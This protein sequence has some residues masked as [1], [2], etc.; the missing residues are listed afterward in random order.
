MELLSPV[1]TP[2]GLGVGMYGKLQ[3]ERKLSAVC[4]WNWQLWSHCLQPPQNTVLPLG[5][6]SGQPLTPVEHQQTRSEQ[7]KALGRCSPSKPKLRASPSCSVTA[8]LQAHLVRPK[9]DRQEMSFAGEN[10]SQKSSQCSSEEQVTGY[11]QAFPSLP[12]SASQVGFRRLGF[13]APLAESAAV[14]NT[15]SELLSSS[16][17]ILCFHSFLRIGSSKKKGMSTCPLTPPQCQ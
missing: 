17:P 2:E 6:P 13:S 4:C 14:F 3:R 7:A 9:P 5:Q 11:L 15:T 1:G 10:S 8:S 16:S 12:G